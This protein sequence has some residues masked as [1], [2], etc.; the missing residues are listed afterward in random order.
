MIT[1]LETAI[2][3]KLETI[4][5]LQA[6]YDYF[7]LNTTGYP[8]ASFELSDFDGEFLDV[9]TN[10]RSFIYNCVII[11]EINKKNLTRDQAKDILYW[12]LDSLITAFDWDQDLSE[13]II[14]K[15]NVTKW[16]MGTFLDKEGSILALNIEIN[17]EVTTTAW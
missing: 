6:V 12:I 4:T 13:G 10:K 11:Q 9:C 8:Y 2:R 7:T 16:Q 15:W 3:T 17:L 14:I 5:E 1:T